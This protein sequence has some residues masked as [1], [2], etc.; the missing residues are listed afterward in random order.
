MNRSDR[1]AVVALGVIL[2]IQATALA[3][4]AWAVGVTVDEPSHLLSATLY[5]RGA[6]NL[7]PR[8]MPPAIKIV[9]GWVPNMLGAPIP[10][11]SPS[12]ERR[13]EWESA[14]AMMSRM[15]PE[16][17][18]RVFFWS[19][20]P[21][22][23]FPLM[24]SLV[25]FLWIREVLGP[26]P[27]AA[28]ALLF[29]FG[30]TSM[31]HGSLFK[32]DQAAAFGYLLFWW[33]AWK[34]WLAPAPRNLAWLTAG[35][36]AGVMAKLSMLLLVA[37]AP[38]VIAAVAWRQRRPRLLAHAAALL[39]AVYGAALATSWFEIRRLH[40]DE[41]QAVRADPRNPAWLRAGA[42]LFRV[43]P[44][45]KLYWDGVVSLAAS[46]ADGNPVYLLGKR[47]PRGSPYYFLVAS[48]VKFTA[49][50]QLL[51]LT[52]AMVA[53]WMLRRGRI[54]PSLAVFLIVPPLLYVG[55]AS[56]ASMQLGVRLIL[57]AVPFAAFVAAFVFAPGGWRWRPYLSAFG[58]LLLALVAAQSARYYP[59]GMSFFN[60]WAG[61]SE[62]GLRY[63]A[64]SNIDWGQDLP[65][66]AEW[67]RANHV[68]HIR[69][70]YFGN[71]T[72]WRFFSDETIERLAPPWGPDLV[73][74]NPYRP[75]PGYYAVSA[76]L[77]PGHFFAAAYR[78]YF[79]AFREATPI[80]RAGHSIFIYRFGEASHASAKPR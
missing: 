62:N 38:V 36:A 4:Q 18:Q 26:W 41:V 13:N 55:L 76:T 49:G 8:D 16:R 80:A 74:S 40:R 32:N 28:A 75:E 59:H 27:A 56:T 45:P 71:D 17:V 47:E 33:R 3:W 50:L 66:L 20:L 64:D 5:W 6:D 52:G 58:G 35:V 43:I 15:K 61:G 46:Q 22:I 29:A 34:Y 72:P 67:V 42:S 68:D 70:F 79:K 31:A 63:L 39:L 9:G 12:F 19:R 21:L 2:V 14:L 60:V 48:A 69:L 78:D 7:L 57:P 54:P 24:A 1:L 51:T 53:A 25:L 77:L 11:D 23:V 73:K 65:S 30:P 44:A 10:F 37:A